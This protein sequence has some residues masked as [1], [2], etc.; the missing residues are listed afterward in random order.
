[1]VVVPGSWRGVGVTASERLRKTLAMVGDHPVTGVGG[2]SIRA[3]PGWWPESLYQL[4]SPRLPGW[5]A[6][7]R[8]DWVSNPRGSG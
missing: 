1:M 5:G 2:V 6:V 7:G 4:G 3:M 8:A